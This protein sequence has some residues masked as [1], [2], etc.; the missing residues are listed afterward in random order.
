MATG[1]DA[2][3]TFTDIYN[4]NHWGCTESVSGPGSTIESTKFLA[5]E[6]ELILLNYNIKSILDIPCG[7]CN[8]I[9]H[10]NF[11][12]IKYIGADI[13]D[14]LIESNRTNLLQYEFHCLDITK[15][16]LPNVD[17]IF[18]RDCLFHLPNKLIFKA[19]SNIKG[20]GALFFLTTS[21]TW[22]AYP[23]EDIE[24]GRW[25]RLN[26]ELPPFNLP[27]PL[28]TIVEGTYRDKSMKM[29]PVGQL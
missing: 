29:W 20:S 4:K 11:K 15:D 8:W 22:K 13:V 26:L 19:L 21:F 18:C 24:V 17:L 28:E 23:N 2:K 3:Q 9:K 25:R 27:K 1:K 12:G 10:L 16:K 7:D 5:K 14:E 6:L